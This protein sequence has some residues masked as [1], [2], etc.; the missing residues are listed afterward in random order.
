M[1]GYPLSRSR[2]NQIEILLLTGDIIISHAA[3]GFLRVRRPDWSTS[4]LGTSLGAAAVIFAAGALDHRVQ[5]YILESPYQDLT[6]AAW[7]RTGLYLPPVLSHVA[8]LGLR[9]VGP[10]FLPHLDEIS[11]LNAIGAVPADA[12]VLI[13]AGDADPLARPADA[14]A[15]Y[16]R[17]RT[18]GMLVL[19][20]NAGH[21]E[22]LE[23]ALDLLPQTMRD[24]F[25]DIA[26]SPGARSAHVAAERS[27]P[28]IS[29]ERDRPG[30]HSTGRNDRKA[31]GRA[32]ER[33]RLRF[34]S[35]AAPKRVARILPTDSLRKIR[36]P[37]NES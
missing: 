9:I 2:D 33:T 20:P 26:S 7:N 35:I 22:L 27:E 14:H 34:G 30:F 29:S 23:S 3:V 25:R 16:R 11:P 4:A 1:R 15:L 36:I 13:L 18:H 10:L 24:F 32:I 12:P 6:V 21:H 8:F 19:M 28:A 5:G 37:G 31:G 17:M